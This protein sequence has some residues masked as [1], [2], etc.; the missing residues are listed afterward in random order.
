[1]A[2][3]ESSL[4]A[5]KKLRE[6]CSVFG[7]DDKECKKLEGYVGEICGVLGK[8]AKTKR[9]KQ[10]SKWQLCIKE[11]RSGKPFDPVAIKQLAKEYKAGTCP[12]GA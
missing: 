7:L 10:L 6:A 1:M 2:Q 3:F 9:K 5:D 4:K 12:S 11:R 8:G